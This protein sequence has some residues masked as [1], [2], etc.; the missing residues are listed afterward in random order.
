MGGSCQRSTLSLTACHCVNVLHNV[1]VYSNKSLSQ[2]NELCTVKSFNNN[3]HNNIATLTHTEPAYA[4]TPLWVD[5]VD[6]TDESTQFKNAGLWVMCHLN[7]VSIYRRLITIMAQCCQIQMLL[8]S[9]LQPGDV[10]SVVGGRRA[11]DAF[12]KGRNP[13]HQL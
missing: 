8:G 12:T 13:L 10:T 11:G 9:A 5:R 4:S 3:F 2:L 6:S 1:T 7:A